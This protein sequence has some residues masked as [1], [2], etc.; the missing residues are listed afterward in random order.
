MK[1]KK[2][3]NVSRSFH[4]YRCKSM[5]SPFFLP[6][7]CLVFIFLLSSSFHPCMPFIVLGSRWCFALY[8]LYFESN[9][10]VRVRFL[11]SCVSEFVAPTSLDVVVRALPYYL[12]NRDVLVAVGA[13]R[14][15]FIIYSVS[16]RE[17]CVS[18]T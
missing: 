2:T 6:F 3:K 11:V 10:S 17:V 7:L 12:F 14:S 1:N 9:Y 16:V 8:R 4:R 5:S 13:Q 18:H 15:Y